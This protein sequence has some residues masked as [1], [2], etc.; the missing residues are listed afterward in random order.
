MWALEPHVGVQISALCSLPLLDLSHL[1]QWLWVGE[2]IHGKCLA[3]GLAH[4]ERFGVISYDYSCIRS[5]DV[6]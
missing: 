2:L 3:Q 4:S 6:Y 1:I 5:T